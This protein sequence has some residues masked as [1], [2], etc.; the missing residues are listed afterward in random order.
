[1]QDFQR[2]DLGEYP[3][4][5]RF[6]RYFFF[7]PWNENENFTSVTNDLLSIRNL[8]SNKPETFGMIG[9]DEDVNRFSASYVIQ[10]PSGGGFMSKHREYDMKEEGDNSYVVYIPLTTRGIDSKTGGAYAFND[11]E[12]INIDDFAQKGDLVIYRGDRYHGVHNI[13]SDKSP[14]ISK[15]DGRL[16]LTTII[17]YFED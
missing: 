7:F 15:V 14:S 12:E 13:D 6:C 1:M 10:Y 2:L 17:N 4:S 11:N 3:A 9:R 16:M 8:I 5:Y